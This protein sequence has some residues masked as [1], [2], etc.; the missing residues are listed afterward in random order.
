[1]SHLN[2]GATIGVLGSGQLGRMM[3]Q[4]ATRLGYRVACF[5][6]DTS[7]TPCAQ[8]GASEVTGSYD[9]LD[10]VA[11]FAKSVDVV[12]FEFENV[13]A[14]AAETAAKYAP[15]RPSGDVLHTTQNRLREKSFLQKIGVPTTIF[16]AVECAADCA[17]FS[18]PAILKTAGFGYD[19]KGQRKV[20]SASEAQA[21]FTELGEPPCILEALVDFAYEASIVGARGIDGTFVAY[22]L[23]RNDHANHILDLTTAPLS[24][25]TDT[26]EASALAEGIFEALG[27]VGVLCVEL[28]VT[29]DGQLL[30]NE[31]APRPHNSGHWSIEGAAT[32]QF[33]QQVRAVCGLPLGSTALQAPGVAMANLLGDLWPE[34]GEPNWAAALGV[35]GVHLHLYGKTQA[36]PGRKMGHLTALAPTPVA[37]ADCVLNTRKLLA[38]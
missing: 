18:Y 24:T 3:T 22:P 29:T 33:E 23:V 19:G 17:D 10:A 11:A 35:P 34:S 31:L 2:P 9:D 38:L 1:M 5:S 28:F 36:R 14:A 13:S 27:V 20:A 15:V 7:P 25:K 4:A 8:V 6:P 37:A 26:G 32:S 21:A 30:V 12:T 16:K